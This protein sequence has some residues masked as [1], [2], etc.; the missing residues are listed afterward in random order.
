MRCDAIRCTIRCDV[1]CKPTML[2]Q[3]Q[4]AAFCLQ[5]LILLSDCVMLFIVGN[6]LHSSV[7]V[8]VIVCVWTRMR[9][10]FRAVDSLNT[11][12][13]SIFCDFYLLCNILCNAMY[14][15]C[16]PNMSVMN[17]LALSPYLFACYYTRMHFDYLLWSKTLCVNVQN[18]QT[19]SNRIFF[20]I[21][22]RSRLQHFWPNSKY[23]L[24]VYIFLW[25]VYPLGRI[26]FCK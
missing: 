14:R 9:M 24:E 13:V 22:Y 8:F 23:P 6:I 7:W 12:H 1:R 20:A 19:I 10:L 15:N 21:N 11:F 16:S 25:N 2:I 26:R 5:V 18:T 4:Y 3:H 17:A